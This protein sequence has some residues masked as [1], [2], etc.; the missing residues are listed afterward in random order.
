MSIKARIMYVIFFIALNAIGNTV[1]SA[2]IAFIAL[3]L[4]WLAIIPALSR[5]TKFDLLHNKIAEKFGG[6]NTDNIKEDPKQTKSN[7]SISEEIHAETVTEQTSGEETAKNQTVQDLIIS[8]VDG[9]LKEFIANPPDEVY[10]GNS[11]YFR[12][13]IN[14]YDS[15]DD[16]LWDKAKN[17]LNVNFNCNIGLLEEVIMYQTGDFSEVESDVKTNIKTHLSQSDEQILQKD[18]SIIDITKS[19]IEIAVCEAVPDGRDVA[20]Y[21]EFH[22]FI[23]CVD[24]GMSERDQALSKATSRNS[25][26]LYKKLDD[27]FKNDKEIAMVAI[28]NNPYTFEYVSNNLKN[29]KEVVMAAVTRNGTCLSYASDNLKN[30]REIVMA[31]VSSDG[32]AIENASDDLKNDREIVMAA[33]SNQ[34]T[35]IQYL[36]DNFKNDKEIV[37]TAASNG[38]YWALELISDEFKNDKEVVMAAIKDDGMVLEHASDELKNDKEVVLA[39]VKN[40]EAALEHA[41]DSLKGDRDILELI[42][43]AHPDL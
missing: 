13:C 18:S 34:G 38:I 22:Y 40:C 16:W 11:G 36:S 42:K 32:D 31:A 28:E 30:D 2:F 1:G 14:L 41:S 15:D 25:Y 37:M 9:A 20:S 29:D 4:P 21:H 12:W 39:A 10:E 43:A 3:A 17:D 8:A 26:N 24:S 23:Y 33:V 6:D 19:N 7:D 27:K 5:V 35:A